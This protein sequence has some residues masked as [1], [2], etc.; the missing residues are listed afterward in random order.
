[1]KG[2]KDT[3]RTCYVKGGPVGGNK[4]AAKMAQ[5]MK[6]FKSGTLHSGSDRGP[7]VKNRKQAVAIALS[8]AKRNPM[9]KAEGG[10]VAK[11]FK[12]HDIGTYTDAKGKVVTNADLPKD[13][14]DAVE[15]YGARRDL[16][17]EAGSKKRQEEH[18]RKINRLYDP[19][20]RTDAVQEMNADG[21]SAGFRERR[22]Y[23]EG[24]RVVTPT[25]KAS[26]NPSQIQ[27]YKDGYNEGVRAEVGQRNFTASQPEPKLKGPKDAIGAFNQGYYE[28]ARASDGQRKTQIEGSKATPK[29]AEGGVVRGKEKYAN[30]KERSEGALNQSYMTDTG[31]WSDDHKGSNKRAEGAKS[32]R[33]QDIHD[34]LVNRPRDERQKGRPKVKADDIRR[35]L[36]GFDNVRFS[37]AKKIYNGEHGYAE[38]GRAMVRS[39]EPL[40]KAAVHKHE[41]NLHPGKPLTKLKSGGPS[42]RGM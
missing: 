24:G 31:F 1:M 23:A 7:A 11:F 10:P 4:G 27:A 36:D 22:G 41:R 6:E 18:Q 34:T 37:L 40:V 16:S 14:R 21:L 29:F 26:A 19:K 25:K 2:Y 15:V 42:R 12:K 5:V 13:I 30:D 20:T 17:R 28:G 9:K 38:G 39:K 33:A 35:E 8:E 32:V 3:T